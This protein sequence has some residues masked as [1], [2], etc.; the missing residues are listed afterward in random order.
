MVRLT[1]GRLHYPPLEALQPE[2]RRVC[3]SSQILQLAHKIFAQVHHFATEKDD[4]G[5]EGE[6]MAYF[7]QLVCKRSTYIP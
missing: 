7:I 4:E 6:E 5:S 1:I 3:C 2:S